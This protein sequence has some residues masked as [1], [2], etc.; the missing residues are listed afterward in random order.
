MK[1]AHVITRLIVGG[2][3]ENTIDTVVGLARRGYDVHLLT[4][5]GLGPEGTLF[6]ETRRRHPGTH[7]IPSLR[8]RPDPL[9]DSLAYRDLVRRFRREKYDI[10][11]THSAKAGIL[12]RFAA[13]RAGTPVV[14]HT[15]HGLP[16]HPH[17]ARWLNAFYLALERR[18]ARVTDHFITVGEVMKENAVAAG[19]GRPGDF[20]TVYSGMDIGRF[21]EARPDPVVRESL[22]IEPD[23]LVVVKIA[24]LFHLKGHEY[25]M[26]A[27]PTILREIP[28]AKFLLVGDGVLRESLEREAEALGIRERFVFAGLIPPG[29]VPGYL[30]LAHVCVHLSLREGLPRALPQALAAGVPVV[31]FDVDGAREVALDGRTGFLIPEGD[32][33]ALGDRVIRL[34]RDAE[35]RRRFA[36]EGRE[37][38]RVRFDRETMVREIAGLYE[39]WFAERSGGER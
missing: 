33:E 22:G 29:E 5:P 27:A 34:L 24:R 38:V 39:K 14:V 30:A 2:A 10:V 26:R 7:M 16:F 25:L 35:L 28:R 15:I 6:E 17:Q 31:A 23:D 9:L 32:V 1:I 21:L 3:Q 12:G 18:A 13:A 19:L 8:R 37:M 4:G 36:E 20:T 11:H